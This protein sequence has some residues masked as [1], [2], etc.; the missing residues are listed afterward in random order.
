[1]YRWES[2]LAVEFAYNFAWSDPV[3]IRIGY[4]ASELVQSPSVAMDYLQHRWPIERGEAYRKALQ[5]CE[6][7][8]RDLLDIETARM[9]FIAAAKEAFLLS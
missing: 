9:D 4:G 3:Y 2:K 7:A 8:T 6:L 1:M 5:S